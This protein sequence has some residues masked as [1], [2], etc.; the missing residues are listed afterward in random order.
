MSFFCGHGPE[1][2][3]FGSDS[4]YQTAVSNV[5]R[6]YAVVGLLEEWDKS[7]AVLEAYIPRFF[8]GARAYL[9]EH[10]E[11]RHM[12]KNTF[13]PPVDPELRASLMGRFQREIQFYEF[14]KQRLHK[15]YMLMEE[16]QR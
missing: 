4:L 14:C 1:C 6:R 13:K 7:L 15:Q 2:D 12:N 11:I 8:R 10:S 16:G 5:E 9:A 3:R